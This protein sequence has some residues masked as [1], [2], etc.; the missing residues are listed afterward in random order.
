MNDTVIPL[1][2]PQIRQGLKDRK[3][4]RVSDATGISFPTLQ[5]LLEGNTDNFSYN[6]VIKVSAY[7]RE[8]QIE[9]MV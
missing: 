7:L 4:G 1:S 6:T 5:R 3:L 9:G 2:L 8:M